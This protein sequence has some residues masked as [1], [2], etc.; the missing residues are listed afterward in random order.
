MPV[1]NKIWKA[2]PDSPYKISID[3]EVVNIKTNHLISKQMFGGYYS[4]GLSINKTSKRLF[5][6]RLMAI[7][8]IPNP[9]NK[10]TVNHKNGIK[11][12]NRL[13][14]LEWATLSEN[15]R[16]ARRAGLN[17][18][19]HG[20]KCNFAKLKNEDIKDIRRLYQHGRRQEDIGNQFSV[21]QGA[22]SRII[23]GLRWSHI[24]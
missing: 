13:E 5:Y 15:C 6:H 14:N 22:I 10:R 20:E 21:G 24:T 11:T 17:K 12:D 8:F 16:H 23:N 9:L 1:T 7:M 19:K 18:G 4:I 2:I 3:G